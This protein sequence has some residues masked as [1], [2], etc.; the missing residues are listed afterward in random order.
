MPAVFCLRAAA[1]SKSCHSNPKVLFHPSDL[2]NFYMSLAQA[3]PFMCL[4]VQRQQAHH[5]ASASVQLEPAFEHC[6]SFVFQSATV[7][8]FPEISKCA[9]TCN[10]LI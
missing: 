10:T 8:S 1:I 7:D 4:L 6:K 9:G 2:F 5:C 3:T